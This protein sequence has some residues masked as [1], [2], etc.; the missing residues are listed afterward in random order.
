MKGL[1]LPSGFFKLCLCSCH[2]VRGIMRNK[3]IMKPLFNKI[4]G[5]CSFVLHQAEPCTTEAEHKQ[6]TLG[7]FSLFL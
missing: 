6:Q 7:G 2:F 4:I 1:P 5:K 3:K